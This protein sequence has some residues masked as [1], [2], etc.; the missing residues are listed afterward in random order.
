[1]TITKKS[2]KQQYRK[3]QSRKPFV[4]KREENKA[5][6]ALDKLQAASAGLNFKHN[7]SKKLIKDAAEILRS[8]K[9]TPTQ[10]AGR[11]RKTNRNKNRSNKTKKNK[12]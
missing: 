11:K 4:S 10:N 5:L 3:S 6:S 12:K 2:R 1:M 7:E 8:L 9:T